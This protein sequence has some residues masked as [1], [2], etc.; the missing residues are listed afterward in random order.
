MK[1][2]TKI[3]LISVVLAVAAAVW[4]FII[5]KKPEA[6]TAETAEHKGMGLN[7]DLKESALEIPKQPAGMDSATSYDAA[8]PDAGTL[9]GIGSADIEKLKLTYPAMYDAY[10]KYKPMIIPAEFPVLTWT[11][12]KKLTTSV[13]LDQL[14]NGLTQAK[15]VNDKAREARVL[16]ALEVELYTLARYGKTSKP[17]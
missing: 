11:G 3:I 1:T 2:K 17:Q 5:R 7:P 12:P 8:V 16:A 10:N 4:Y 15:A 6:E 14:N 13:W 9:T